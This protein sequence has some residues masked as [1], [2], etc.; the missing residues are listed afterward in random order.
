[1]T[2][3]HLS[4][5]EIVIMLPAAAAVFRRHRIDFCCKG[6]TLLAEAAQAVGLD[7]SALEAEL[8]TLE[9]PGAHAPA[10]TPGL[11]AHIIE[12]YHKVHRL[13]FPAV[14]DMARQ[15]ESEHLANIDCPRGLTDLLCDMFEDLEDHQHKEEAVLF[16]AMARGVGSVL[17]DPIARM[18]HDHHELGALLALMA[19]LTDDFI[20]PASACDTWRALYA[21]CSKLDMDLREHIHLEN[22]ILFQ[23]FL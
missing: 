1:M 17:R 8:H 2:L 14:I 21:G 22:N 12:R 15:V 7:L 4:T 3:E 5:G 19:V 10:E 13:E 11:I 18:M 6:D 16:P 20:A 9:P 23:R